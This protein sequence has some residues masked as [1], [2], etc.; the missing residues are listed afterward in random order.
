MKNQRPFYKKRGIDYQV[1]GRMWTL[2]RKYYQSEAIYREELEKIFYCRWQ[3]ACREEEIPEP[4]HFL[5]VPVGSESIILVRNDQGEIRAHF[6]V[7]RHRGTRLC[8]E[9]KGQFT[10]GLIRCPYH[11]WQYDLSGTLKTAP[12]M[13]GVSG[14][15][16]A[17]YTLFSAHVSLWGEIGLRRCLGSNTSSFQ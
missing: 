13:N 12:L 9:E 1:P 15:Q 2:P 4:G 10:P 17:D 11:A 7:C 16:K 5:V 6:N 8:A 3:L 14:F